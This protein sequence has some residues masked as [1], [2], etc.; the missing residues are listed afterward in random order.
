[1]GSLLGIDVGTTNIKIVLSDLMGNVLDIA[2]RPSTLQMPFD[3]ASEM[4]ME[5][6]WHDICILTKE[7]KEK[8]PAIWSSIEGVGVSAQG[9][10]LWAVDKNGRPVGNAVLWNDTR[11]KNLQVITGNYFD[12]FLIK[13]SATA[14]FPGAF[15]LI[16]KWIKLNEP[17]RFLCINK[18][19]H[20]K[21]WI[22]YKLTDRIVSDFSD[23]STAGIN[24]FSHQFIYELFDLLDISEAK[25]MLPPLMNS[26]DIIG[27][28]HSGAQKETGIP[29]GVPVVAGALDVVATLVGA[30]VKNFGESCT[31]IG[32]TLCNEVLLDSNS[33]DVLNRNG[34]TLCGIYPDQYVRVMAT[35]N[36]SS[37]IDWAKNIFFS[38]SGFPELEKKMSEIPAGSRGLVFHPYLKGERAPFR[39]PFA[40]G[41]FYGLTSAHTSFDMFRAV[42]EGLVFSVKDCYD[43]LPAVNGRIFLVG[44]GAVSDLIC[45]MI[46][47]ILNHEISRPSPREFGAMGIIQ[48]LKIA[49]EISDKTEHQQNNVDVFIPDPVENQKLNA[50]YS[51]F[52]SVREQMFDFW[53]G[54][55]D[56]V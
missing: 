53:K 36:G 55:F 56:W 3:G 52:L 15:P 18:I 8:N 32:T 47:N 28:I 51:Q 13:N 30:G 29:E 22:N 45:Q 1:M 35:L 39:N 54:R 5:L 21:D 4:D 26:S 42:Y 31:I 14:L 16:L 7:L 9:D 41:G 37:T 46:A 33:V 10:G 2:R 44:G 27:K 11:T 48:I 20:C 19:F 40:C 25:E 12:D 34:S 38:D 43:T 23:F 6:L 50:V 17:E 24:I 49:L